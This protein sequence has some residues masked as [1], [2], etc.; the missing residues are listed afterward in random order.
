MVAKYISTPNS[1]ILAVTAANQ[2]F[3]TSEA[4]Q[5]AKKYDPNGMRLSLVR[6]I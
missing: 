2:D 3:S 6:F 1:I 5:F 4:L